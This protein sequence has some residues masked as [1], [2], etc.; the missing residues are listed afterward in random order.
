MSEEVI[1]LNA[2]DGIVAGVQEAAERIKK[3]ETPEIEK[4]Q[5]QGIDYVKLPFML[6]QMT[7]EYPIWSWEITNRETFNVEIEGK[8]IP[9]FFIIQGKLKFFDN[10]VPREIAALAA[11]RIQYKKDKSDFVDIGNDIK[12]A[13][14][15]CLKKAL[16]M[17]G[18]ASDVYQGETS[19]KPENDSVEEVK[20]LF[21]DAGKDPTIFLQKVANGEVTKNNIEDLKAQ[22]TMFIQQRQ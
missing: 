4:Y 14:T 19:Q 3:Y 5:V 8:T 18:I 13:N 12:A 17:L 9:R 7:K 10:G 21:S 1:N 20:Q 11:H 22:L 15:D 16:S 6:E 2:Y